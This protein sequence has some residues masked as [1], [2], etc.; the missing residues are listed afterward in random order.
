MSDPDHDLM[1]VGAAWDH[2]EECL[3]ELDMLD[4]SRRWFP[5]APRDG[6]GV[7]EQVRVHRRNT[8]ETIDIL[9]GGRL[10]WLGHNLA[11]VRRAEESTRAEPE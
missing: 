7:D 10:L 2:I 5:S 4:R 3:D 6:D 9:I 11:L 1:D 8:L